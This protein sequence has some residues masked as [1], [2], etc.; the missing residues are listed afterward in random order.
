MRRTD[1]QLD[2]QALT[3]IAGYAHWIPITQG[4]YKDHF[5]TNYPG[6]RWN[7]IIPVLIEKGIVNMS[8]NDPDQQPLSQGLSISK[9][10]TSVWISAVTGE[11]KQFYAIET[12]DV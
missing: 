11:V 8:P 4:I 5:R 6:W 7:Q 3:I 12:D 10:V 2:I 1:L 9:E